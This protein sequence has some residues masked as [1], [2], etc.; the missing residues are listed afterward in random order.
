MSRKIRLL[1]GKRVRLGAIQY[2]GAAERKRDLKGSL[3]AGRTGKHVGQPTA[4]VGRF[5]RGE[6]P[7]SDVAFKAE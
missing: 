1:H 3:G 7:D 6:Q 5:E 4:V 2:N